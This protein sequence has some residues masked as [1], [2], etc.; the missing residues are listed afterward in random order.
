MNFDVPSHNQQQSKIRQHKRK[1]KA[2]ATY[3][4][5]WLGEDS[6]M[7]T[8]L[9]KF[10]YT[11]MPS[12]YAKAP[13]PVPLSQVAR[14]MSLSHVP[15]RDGRP[16]LDCPLS[17]NA[18]AEGPARRKSH[19]ACRPS[20]NAMAEGPASH[21]RRMSPVHVARRT[22]VPCRMSPSLVARRKSPVPCRMSPVPCRMSPVV[23]PFCR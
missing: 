21:A 1:Q 7:I 10:A 20:Q 22:P 9:V 18:M 6:E 4:F 5:L 14:R 3:P 17:L 8:I 19:V 16:S 11:S 15:K 23:C 13:S 2:V 12:L